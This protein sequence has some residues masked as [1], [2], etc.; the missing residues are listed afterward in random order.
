MAKHRASPTC[1]SCHAI[2]DPLGFS[3]ENFDGTGYPRKI[4][5]E[6]I[7]ILARITAVAD[8]PLLLPRDGTASARLALAL[9]RH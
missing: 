3:L 4:P 9:S 8:P 2:M 5:G 7:H 1:A 6:Q